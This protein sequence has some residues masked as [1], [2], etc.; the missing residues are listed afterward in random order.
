[1]SC[2]RGRGRGRGRG[3][4]L[5]FRAHA[6]AFALLPALVTPVHGQARIMVGPEVL[7]S[8]D[9]DAP[10]MET[11]L[12]INPK[13]WKNLVGGA[14]T[15][16]RPDGG[17]ATKTYASVDGGHTWQ[18]A[19]FPE[20]VRFGG[21]DPQVAFTSSGTAIFVTLAS[22]QDELGRT[23][24]FL[25]AYRS[26]DGGLKWSNPVDLRYSWDHPQIVVDHTTGRY[27]NRIYVGVL[28]GY[29][30]YRVGVFRSE[31][32]G[33]TW[34]GPS[35]AANGAGIKGINV[36]NLGVFSDGTLF[37]PYMDFEF[38]QQKVMKLTEFESSAWFVM[39]SD[40]GI[41]FSAPRKISTTVRPRA[42]DRRFV[43]F[44]QFT[45]DG[46]TSAYRD[47][48]YMVETQV[49]RGRARI[50]VNT[51]KDRGKTWSGPRP[52]DSTLP[53][54]ASQYMPAIAVSD[55]G[56]VAVTW[57]DTRHAKNNQTYRQYFSASLDGGET[58]L[59]PVPVATQDADTYGAGNVRLQAHTARFPADSMRIGLISAASRWAA[60]GDY[61][62]L[63]A[64][65]RGV[66]HP[67]W[68]D[69]RTGTFQVMTAEVTIAR[70]DVAM[71]AAG[72]DAG[73]A[74]VQ[75]TVTNSIELV[76]DPSRY[77]GET[78][79]AFLPIRL[80]N[81]GTNPIHGPIRVI[82]RGFGSG[83]GKLLQEFAPEVLNAA[84]GKT[85]D[86]AEFDFTP[87]IGTSG[88]L[89]PGATTGAVELRL[90]VKDPLQVPDLHIEV[91]GR[92]EAV[93]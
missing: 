70:A 33:R 69:A 7:V 37:L 82:I 20:Q 83:E 14:I 11:H 42:G 61:I 18:D 78:K 59:T 24:G 17:F 8:R 62:G 60:G 4:T 35:E 51:S 68:P 47:R 46:G 19:S 31:D 2:A 44:P 80:K 56:V 55:S 77:D 29:P 74:L 87:Q 9:G 36:V 58:W 93:R 6:F 81:V 53:D 40:G 50:V 25:H 76:M 54:G 79:T 10:H 27:A 16:T 52:L 49:E 26:E 86:G 38:D 43:G 48:I 28:Y 84:N 45:V 66:F 63:A 88:V 15:M 92:V 41:T 39:S 72:P 65:K 73:A 67:F 21:A 23:R 5:R 30:V 91:R 89:M 75:R 13:N 34:I 90:R 12:A 85:G 1:M 3:T 22:G 71:K 64:D 57:S 32:D